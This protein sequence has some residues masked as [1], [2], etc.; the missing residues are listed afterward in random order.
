VSDNPHDAPHAEAYAE[1]PELT[2]EVKN[3]AMLCHL[4]ALIGLVTLFFFV[5]PLVVW[6]LKRDEHPFI[7]EQGKEAVNFQLSMLIYKTVAALTCLF[8]VGFILLPALVVL[9]V[10]LVI[11]ASAKASSGISYRYPLTIRFLS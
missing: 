8:L 11:M 6:L 10:I 7:D 9:D 3:W 1:Y 4:T 5:G 2:P